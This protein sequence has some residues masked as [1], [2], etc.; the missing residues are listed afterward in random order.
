MKLLGTAQR[1]A[2]NPN[3]RPNK[4]GK[5][6]QSAERLTAWL[7]THGSSCDLVA[8]ARRN[9]YL[10]PWVA[11]ADTDA[12][13]AHAGLVAVDLAVRKILPDTPVCHIAARKTRAGRSSVACFSAQ[14]KGAT[15]P[16][17]KLLAKGW[18]KARKTSQNSRGF[19]I[20]TNAL[21]ELFAWRGAPPGFPEGVLEH[22]ARITCPGTL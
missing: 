10:S 15:A 8:L 9:A 16:N 4:V 1:A 13:A 20:E 2:E 17:L 18:C 6:E 19:G 12:T 7:K 22:W 3:T 11:L 21:A 14:D 5:A